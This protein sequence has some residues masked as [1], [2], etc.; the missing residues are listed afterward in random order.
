VARRSSLSGLCLAISLVLAAVAPARAQPPYDAGLLTPH[1]VNI[2]G[3]RRLNI[4]CFGH[5]APVVV[6]DQGG[7]GSMLSWQKVEKPI[8]AITRVCLYD[9]A[10]FGY[11]DPP[12]GPITA[13][14]ETD[15]LHVLL[16]AAGVRR[17]VVI[18][19]HS[20]GGFYATVYA[21]RFAKDVAGLVLVDPGIAGQTSELTPQQREAQMAS[22]HAGE[23]RLL[24][25]AALAR[26]GKLSLDEARRCMSFPPAHTPQEEAYLDG[27]IIHPFWYEAEVSA[28][29]NYFFGPDGGPSLDTQQEEAVRRAFGDMPLI[30]LTRG[31]AARD[32][33]W[34]DATSKAFED[35]WKAG[36]DALAARSSRGKSIVV[37]GAGHFI[38]LAKPDAVI[39]AIEEVVADVRRGR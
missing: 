5:G 30:V 23:E 16:R 7:E 2:G 29:R 21:D 27:M 6:F 35:Y 36:H 37:P 13:L 28:S 24:D 38:Q 22:S 1:L 17:P 10:G 3:G 31:V 12:A 19:G 39:A 14:S 4:V 15:D 9:R 26:Q 8:A 34:D 20:I 18:V 32:P 33:G 25:C 11:S